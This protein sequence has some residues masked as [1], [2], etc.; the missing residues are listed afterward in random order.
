MRLLRS[1]RTLERLLPGTSAAHRTRELR[2]MA[3]HVANTPERHAADD[4]AAWQRATPGSSGDALHTLT[5]TLSNDEFVSACLPGVAQ[6]LRLQAM[7]RERARTGRPL[8]YVLGEWPFCGL[9]LL[10]RPPTL[11]PR[12]ETE[13]WT[14]TLIDRY[15]SAYRPPHAPA[16][17]PSTRRAAGR[18]R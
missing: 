9:S 14:A 6:R 8:Q 17:R 4:V 15:L 2:W 16:S 12:P 11:I 5:H 10:T 1:V 3:E 7:V 13:Q 18:G